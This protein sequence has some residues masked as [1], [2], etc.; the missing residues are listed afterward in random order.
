M[1][2]TLDR[3]RK[4]KE[5]LADIH[6]IDLRVE[7]LEEELEAINR[8]N[9]EDKMEENLKNISKVEQQQE[10]LIGNKEK[11]Y[12]EQASKKRELK[13]IENAMT[14]LTED[15]RKVIQIVYIQHRK[16]YVVQD[17]L[18]L[19]YPRVKQLEKQA[20]TKMEKYL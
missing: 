20:A 17:K 14:I 18:H 10:E 3:V 16:Y 9:K 5:T 13:R 8:M 11:L 12:R 7:E 6:E 1:S 19:S 15:E 4:Y 2:S